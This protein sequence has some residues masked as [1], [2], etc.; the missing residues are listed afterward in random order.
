QKKRETLL[1]RFQ[2]GQLEVLVATDVA[3]RGLHSDGVKYVYNYD[4][5]F[6]AEDYV[7]R[8]GRTAR[9]GEEG[10]AISFAC[11]RYA[12][13]LPDI[14]AYIEQKIPTAPV[15]ADLLVARPRPR[16]EPVEGEESESVSAIFKEAREQRAADEERRGGGRRGSGG[17]GSGRSGGP[18]ARRGSA[19][20][21]RR[22]DGEASDTPR[23]GTAAAVAADAAA[24]EAPRK[25]RRRRRKP[26]GERA[27]N[28]GGQQAGGAGTT[29]GQGEGGRKPPPRAEA[30]RR[31]RAPAPAAPGPDRAPPSGTAAAAPGSAK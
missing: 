10:D 28:E 9:L 29:A 2:K 14:E 18:K 17:G 19:G 1:A 21:R 7:H 24:G 20:P 8:I 15:E 4:L 30:E 16:R 5:P 23:D 11:E 12:M 13:S 31:R 6:D 27:G 3:A 22:P 26:A 25:R